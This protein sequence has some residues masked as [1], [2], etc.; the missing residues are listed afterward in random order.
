MAL[1]TSLTSASFKSQRKAFQEFQPMAGV[2]P[3]PASVGNGRLCAPFCTSYVACREPLFTAVVGMAHSTA[4][5]SQS[6]I[7]SPRTKAVRARPRA[8]AVRRLV[9]L[10]LHFSFKATR[11]PPTLT[12]TLTSTAGP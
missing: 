10:W 9:R 4:E 7:V 11:A 8:S 1:A 3:T 5:G 6:R 2:L 12:L